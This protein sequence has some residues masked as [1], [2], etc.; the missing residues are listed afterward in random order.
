MA[1]PPPVGP[2][3]SHDGGPFPPQGQ[4]QSVPGQI[5]PYQA[6]P[7]PW[8]QA[9]G[10][11]YPALQPPPA[12]NGLAIAALVFGLL[13][14]LPG[15]G[16]L[17]GVV[18]LVQIRKKGERGKGMAVAGIVL[19]TIGTLLVT[20]AF[21][22]GGARDAWDGFRDAASGAGTTFSVEKGECFDTPSG[23]LEGYAYDVDTVPCEGE[24]DA[25]VFA[26]FSMPDG[27]YPGDDE[28]TDAADEQCYALSELYAMD[29]WALPDDV[30]VYYFTPTRQSWRYGDREITCMFG[31][32]DAEGGL[33]GSLRQDE[34]TLDDDQFAFLE[35][36]AILDDALDGVPDTEYVED[37]LPAHKAWASQVVQALEEQTRTLRA[38][39]WEPDAE[40]AVG[41]Y[42][43]ALD[44]AREE[45][46]AASKATD[47]ETFS[48]HWNKAHLLTD[49]PKAV[50][51]REALGL[52]TTPP[53]YDDEGT[54]EDGGAGGGGDDSGVEV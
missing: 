50:T 19:S 38:H 1:T 5:Y 31:N 47:A 46:R 17:L 7:Q 25:E 42:A 13:C 4:P 21:A 44:Q 39:D 10:R 51:A 11:T 34:T 36:D 18:A 41:D 53:T 37:D 28:V 45:W 49:G 6:Q 14:L 8:G 20:L 27:G 43:D 54:D 30:D 35:A 32:T 29:S 48:D 3:P 9:W 16:L 52:D 23:S 15:V 26:D 33:T 24:H 40:R 22:T 12:V 2:R